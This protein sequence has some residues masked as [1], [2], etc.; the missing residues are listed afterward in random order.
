MRRSSLRFRAGS[1]G[2]A[3]VVWMSFA[4]SSMLVPYA[5]GSSGVLFQALREFAEQRPCSRRFATLFWSRLYNEAGVDKYVWPTSCNSGAVA[6]LRFYG[7]G[8]RRNRGNAST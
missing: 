4:L 1:R 6:P 7:R 2:R 8:L 3:F 5:A